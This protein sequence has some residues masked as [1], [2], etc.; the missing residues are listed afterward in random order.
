MSFTI[1]TQQK[2]TF[3]EEQSLKRQKISQS[4]F[5][6]NFKPSLLTKSNLDK[7]N[8]VNQPVIDSQMDNDDFKMARRAES[9]DKE[10][11]TKPSA[12][13]S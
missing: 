6:A 2:H 9:E 4:L 7:L 12:P 11:M 10:V 5:G 1:N 3:T 13:N 8:K